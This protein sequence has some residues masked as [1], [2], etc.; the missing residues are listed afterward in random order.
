MLNTAFIVAMSEIIRRLVEGASEKSFLRKVNGRP[1]P[2]LSSLL[3]AQ[4]ASSRDET[5]PKTLT[6]NRSKW[7]YSRSSHRYLTANRSNRGGRPQFPYCLDS[8]KLINCCRRWERRSIGS[9]F[10]KCGNTSKQSLSVIEPINAHYRSA[11]KWTH[12]QLGWQTQTVRGR[13]SV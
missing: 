9:R 12:L 5:I 11:P 13:N 6:E 4:H 1:T 2:T 10:F 8:D 3:L 7:K